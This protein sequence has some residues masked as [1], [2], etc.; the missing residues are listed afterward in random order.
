M[1]SLTSLRQR[2]GMKLLLT[3]VLSLPLLVQAAEPLPS[4]MR[5]T[6]KK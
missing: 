4:W 3:L 6:L 2:H 1:T 5:K